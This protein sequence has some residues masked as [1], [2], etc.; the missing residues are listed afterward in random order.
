MSVHVRIPTPLRRYAGDRASVALEAET[1]GSLMDALFEECP[2][3]KP[4]LVGED[5]KIRNFVNIFVNGEDARHLDG[6][7]TSLRDGDK[8]AIVPAIAGGVELTNAEILRYSRHL[9]LPEVT[10]D[11]QRKLRNG[12]VLLIGAGG[13]GSPAALSP[14]SF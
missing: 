1:L 9:I 5:A 11:G 4:H 3:L 8:V 12:S 14:L 7:L 13:L 10:I 2:D 6:L